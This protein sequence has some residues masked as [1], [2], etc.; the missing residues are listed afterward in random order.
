MEREIER[1]EPR[2]QNK[3]V[4]EWNVNATTNQDKAKCI[5]IEHIGNTMHAMPTLSLS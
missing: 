3:N 1:K 4:L 2:G 5:S